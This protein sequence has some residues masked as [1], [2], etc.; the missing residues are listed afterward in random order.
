MID[1]GLKQSRNLPYGVLISKILTL[2]G[3][4]ESR[5]KKCSCNCSNV[6]NKNTL[7][8]I[9]LVKTL[10]GWRFKDE[11]NM[12]A[13]S[14]SSPALNGD[15]NNFIPETKFERFVVEQFSRLEKKVDGLY[16]KKNRNDSPIEDSNEESTDEDSMEI[17]DS[18]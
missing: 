14:G 10:N 18:E 11:E 1:V 6:I 15:H 9:S 5:E 7:S 4:D 17:S 3:V 13:S 12:D 8:S 2:Q 16:Q